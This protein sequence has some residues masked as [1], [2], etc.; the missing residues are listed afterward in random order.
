MQFNLIYILE[1]AGNRTR[2][3]TQFWKTYLKNKKQG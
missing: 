2:D 1:K 3:S